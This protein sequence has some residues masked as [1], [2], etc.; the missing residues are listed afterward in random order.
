MSFVKI[1]RELII[2]SFFSSTLKPFQ[3]P[4][5]FFC[6]AATSGEDSCHLIA[7]KGVSA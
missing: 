6:K 1:K 5:S 4:C 7:G 3:S 2:H